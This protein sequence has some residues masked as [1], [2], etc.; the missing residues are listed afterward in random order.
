MMLASIQH[1]RKGPDG[2]DHSAVIA[3]AAGSGGRDALFASIKDKKG[4]SAADAAVGEPNASASEGRAAETAAG[5]SNQHQVSAPNAT[6]VEQ[7]Q[8]RAY[9]EWDVFDDTAEED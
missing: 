5:V 1:G 6:G 9:V 2:P 7:A 8:S 3:S 4:S